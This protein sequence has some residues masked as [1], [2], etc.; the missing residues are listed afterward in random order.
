M[1]LL[2][3]VRIALNRRNAFV[4]TFS[5]PSGDLVLQELAS[6]CGIMKAAPNDPDQMS[7]FE[8][9]RDVYLHITSLLRMTPQDV[10]RIV[11]NKTA[12]SGD[13]YDDN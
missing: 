4:Q 9:Q 2:E 12:E 8:G 1:S 13:P 11:E 7:R 10:R 5:G 6:Y 3:R